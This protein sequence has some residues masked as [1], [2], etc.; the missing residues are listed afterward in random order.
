MSETFIKSLE[1]EIDVSLQ[2]ET[3]SL[4]T[5]S[6]SETQSLET[7]SDQESGNGVLS[8]I[9]S[10]F[11]QLLNS[12]Q[13]I[14]EQLDTNSEILQRL[15]KYNSKSISFTYNGVTTDFNDIIDT[16]HQSSLENIKEHAHINFGE[17]LIAFLENH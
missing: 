15:T 4:E 12:S 16:I 14:F 3:Q 17:L 2:C 10:E 7:E 6:E 8:E 13:Y 9:N 11:L 5:E 1:T